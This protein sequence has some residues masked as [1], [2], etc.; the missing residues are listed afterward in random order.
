MTAVDFA[1]PDDPAIAE[2]LALAAPPESHFVASVAA[3]DAAACATAVHVE[4]LESLG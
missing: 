2:T 1:L 4:S 3:V